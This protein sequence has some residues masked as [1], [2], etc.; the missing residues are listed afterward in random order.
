MK[1]TYIVFIL[2]TTIFTCDLSGQSSN[3]HTQEHL[4]VKDSLLY[5]MRQDSIETAELIKKNDSLLQ[6]VEFVI[7]SLNAVI[8]VTAN[9][10]SAINQK[11]RYEIMRDDALKLKSILNETKTR[12][13]FIRNTTRNTEKK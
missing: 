4:T 5:S 1:L 10:N 9:N 7:D 12:D 11:A 3:K 13:E 8:E 2:V 6:K